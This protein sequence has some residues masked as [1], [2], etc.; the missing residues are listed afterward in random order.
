MMEW[1]PG[2]LIE[3][4]QGILLLA[5]RNIPAGMYF[6]RQWDTIS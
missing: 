6:R 1:A 3:A 5:L 4:F 2:A